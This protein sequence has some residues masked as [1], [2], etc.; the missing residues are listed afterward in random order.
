MKPEQ[1]GKG[2][3]MWHLVDQMGSLGSVDDGIHFKQKN[4]I[5]LYILKRSLCLW[6]GEWIIDR[7]SC[8]VSLDKRWPWLVLEQNQ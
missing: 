8:Y 2:Q 3:A 4:H 1:R 5:M 6:F 7:E